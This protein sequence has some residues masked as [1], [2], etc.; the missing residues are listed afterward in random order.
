MEGVWLAILMQVALRCDYGRSLFERLQSLGH[1]VHLLDVQYRM[2]PAISM[3]PNSQFY[4]G[5]VQDGDNVLKGR[6]N[7]EPC[8]EI[9]PGPYQFI[10]VRDGREQR[11]EGQAKS[12]K[13][14]LEVEIV[15]LLIS[16]IH[17]G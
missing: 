5:K 4:G 9:F 3:F 7:S 16:R 1:P 14:L 11:D 2:H 17:E 13:N 6:Y 15:V 12:W 10:N 8:Q